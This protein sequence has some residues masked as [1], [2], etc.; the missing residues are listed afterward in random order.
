[1]TTSTKTPTCPHCNQPGLPHEMRFGRCETPDCDVTYFYVD[2]ENLCIVKDTTNP[3]PVCRTP[4]E[5]HGDNDC[6]CQNPKCRVA[7]FKATVPHRQALIQVQDT[8]SSP[9]PLVRFLLSIPTSLS[10]PKNAQ[11]IASALVDVIE[12]RS[13][14]QHKW[15][16]QNHD[17]I[18][19]AAILSEECGEF[20]QAALQLKFGG[21]KACYLRKEAVQ[22]A[23]VALQILECM[24]RNSR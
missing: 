11:P 2:V 23:A 21:E 9:S 3:C 15:G 13:A 20:A 4:G 12:E 17:P 7:E 22:C 19:W 8:W 5:C 24:E 10:S 1:M 16:E 14:Q 6:L 18:T